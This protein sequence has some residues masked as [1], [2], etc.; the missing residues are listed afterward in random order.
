VFELEMKELEKTLFD[1]MKTF[2]SKPSYTPK[3]VEYS[4]LSNN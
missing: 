4:I 2:S 1:E 3:E